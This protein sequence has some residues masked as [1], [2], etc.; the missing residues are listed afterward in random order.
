[1]DDNN[2]KTLIYDATHH[3]MGL[4]TM[5]ACEALLYVY[6][7][8]IV[9]LSHSVEAL[10]VHEPGKVFNRKISLSFFC[11]NSSISETECPPK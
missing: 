1:M 6:E 4:R 11:S 9:Q 2:K 8:P 7:V 5:T 3:F 10:A